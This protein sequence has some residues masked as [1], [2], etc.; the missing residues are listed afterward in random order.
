MIMGCLVVCLHARLVVYVAGEGI[1]LFAWL[2][3]VVTPKFV[4]VN[5]GLLAGFLIVHALTTM[6]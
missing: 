3:Q 6:L 4:G 1:G 5:N 2:A